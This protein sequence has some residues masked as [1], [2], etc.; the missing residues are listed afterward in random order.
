MDW[1]AFM[2]VFGLGYSVGY[3]TWR[4]YNSRLERSVRELEY[5]IREAQMSLHNGFAIEASDWLRSVCPE[6]IRR[7]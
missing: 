1:L 3:L 7:G 6:N 2:F 4:R 5:G